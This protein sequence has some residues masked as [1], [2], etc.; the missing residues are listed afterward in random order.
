MKF[1]LFLSAI[2]AYSF[3]NSQILINEYSASNVDGINDAFGDKEDWI[4]LYNTTSA[5]VDLTGWYLSY[6]S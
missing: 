6:R 3:L 4:E 1:A 5:N 2:L